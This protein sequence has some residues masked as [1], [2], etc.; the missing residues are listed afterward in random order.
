M[1]D[2]KDMRKLKN[3][4]EQHPSITY[5]RYTVSPNTVGLTIEFE[6]ELAGGPTFKPRITIPC[7]DPR[8]DAVV[9]KLAFRLGL[10]ELLSYWK[11]CCPAKII[12]EAAPLS[13]NEHPFWIGLLRKGLGEFFFLN[14]IP[15]SIDVRLESD[16]ATESN[17]ET[18]GKQSFKHDLQQ[19]Q[20]ELK[21]SASLVMV[22]G[23]KDSITS[24]EILKTLRE[25]T[26][27]PF[28]A[29][30]LNPIQ[31]SISAINT[32]D[33]DSHLTCTRTID[34]KLF[35]LNRLN[36]FNGHTP[37]S[38]LL[39]FASSLTAYL[40]NIQFVFSSNES[41]ASEGN[42]H[43]NGFEINH[44]YSKSLE[45]E[46][47]F[48]TLLENLS[49]PVSY[50]SLLR[51]LNE[52]Q[53]CKLFSRSKDYHSLFQSCNRTQTIKAKRVAQEQGCLTDVAWCGLCPKCIFT[54]LCLACFLDTRELAEIFGR[55]PSETDTF[56]STVKDLAGQGEYKPFEC[57]G[58]FEEVRACLQHLLQISPSPLATK[59][60]T[61]KDFENLLIGTTPTL[62]E[63]LHRWN[64]NTHLSPH[65]EALVRQ[66]VTTA[67]GTYANH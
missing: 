63:L 32:A 10:V 2:T 16:E 31:S 48:R 44:Q 22:G 20:S 39:A 60:G 57:V 28:H 9:N 30:T 18:H 25:S 12:I 59:Q 13:T 17:N 53:I 35:E 33:C 61:I 29:F 52:L 26:K 11:T 7:K 46:T 55:L 58:T 14:N 1:T 41:S 6:F 54:F 24:L 34:P 8:V 27:A 67:T 21:H 5:R 37:F 51:P 66:A 65:H 47:E 38:A 45:F 64:S 50:A 49:V 42:T 23:G 43:Y 15:P 40:N 62:N 4:R 19:N 36:Y 3:L 56:Y